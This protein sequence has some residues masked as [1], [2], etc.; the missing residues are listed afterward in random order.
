VGGKKAAVN[1]DQDGSKQVIRR[2]L[3][4]EVFSRE[5]KERR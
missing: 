2:R 4:L 1:S 3:S 5:L